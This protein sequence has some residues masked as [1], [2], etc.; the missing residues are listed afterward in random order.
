MLMLLLTSSYKTKL[1]T[2]DDCNVFRHLE[3]T[4]YY[5]QVSYKKYTN[6]N[7]LMF[8]E[9]IKIEAFWTYIFYICH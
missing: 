3:G 9:A 4:L 8:N 7:T 2:I 6:Y 1:N 5:K